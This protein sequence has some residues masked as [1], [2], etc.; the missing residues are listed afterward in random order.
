MFGSVAGS[1]L[2]LESDCA[3]DAF[4]DLWLS[5]SEPPSLS[6]DLLVPGSWNIWKMTF[7]MSKR[8]I[9]EIL[10]QKEIQFSS[11]DIVLPWPQ[12]LFS[13]TW[14]PGLPQEVSPSAAS[15]PSMLSWVNCSWDKIQRSGKDCIKI[16][17]GSG[18]F[19]QRESSAHIYFVEKTPS[20]V[21]TFCQAVMLCLVQ[22]QQCQVSRKYFQLFAICAFWHTL[23]VT[24][25]AVLL[26]T[27]VIPQICRKCQHFLAKLTPELSKKM[28]L[29]EKWGQIWFFR[30][31]KMWKCIFLRC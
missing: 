12:N 14:A 15:T 28:Q 3:A 8:E 5:R 16:L 11:K 29:N 30:F 23:A 7:C 26:Q 18:R 17:T 31:A 9:K 1:C 25:L 24:A 20:A 27:N 19:D 22:R 6:R 4:R 21:Y 10:G 13:V 2:P